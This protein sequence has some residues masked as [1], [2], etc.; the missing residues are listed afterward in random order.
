[1]QLKPAD[2]G[3]ELALRIIQKR[4]GIRT[5]GEK[6]GATETTAFSR[7]A[8][9]GSGLE[10]EAQLRAAHAFKAEAYVAL[11]GVAMFG[12]PGIFLIGLSLH[13]G[14]WGAAFVA[15]IV[16]VAIFCLFAIILAFVRHQWYIA[17]VGDATIVNL[18]EEETT[19][20]QRELLQVARE[21]IR[22]DA[23]APDA[24]QSLRDALRL[25]ANAAERLP[26]PTLPPCNFPPIPPAIKPRRKPTRSR[27]PRLNAAPT[28]L[29][30]RWNP[31][32]TPPY[33]ASAPTPCAANCPHRSKPCASA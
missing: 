27:K 7:W 9:K 5:I 21:L 14:K 31:Q 16:T 13:D 2:L 6:R 29:T 23:I 30:V 11:F 1:M 4:A 25:L 8:T 22:H 3:D 32:S 20:L 26:A 12:A 19:P 33:S 15:A 24:A 28:P 10:G 18:L 17:P